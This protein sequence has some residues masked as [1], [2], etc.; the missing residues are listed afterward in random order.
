MIV[1]ATAEE[2]EDKRARKRA[3]TSF[4]FERLEEL[5]GELIRGRRPMKTELEGSMEEVFIQY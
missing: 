5:E 1:A 3:P 4:I 2:L